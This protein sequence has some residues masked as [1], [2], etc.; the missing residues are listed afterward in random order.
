MN[1][2]RRSLAMC[3]RPLIMIAALGPLVVACQAGSGGASNSAPAAAAN[4]RHD[5]Q[6]LKPVDTLPYPYRDTPFS[7]HTPLE[8]AYVDYLQRTPLIPDRTECGHLF[9]GQL[10][11]NHFQPRQSRTWVTDPFLAWG[12]IWQKGVVVGPVQYLY[13]LTE[14]HELFGSGPADMRRITHSCFVQYPSLTESSIW[15]KGHVKYGIYLVEGLKDHISGPA[16]IAETAP[17]GPVERWEPGIR[18]Y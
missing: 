11:A 14:V 1:L 16:S 9:D 4:D 2:S 13:S 5:W 7:P 12:G 3:I 10:Q 6:M 17:P 8:Q 18:Y 15:Q